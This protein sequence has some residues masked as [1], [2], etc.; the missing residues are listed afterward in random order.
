MTLA[1]LHKRLDDL[2]GRVDEAIRIEREAALR[3]MDAL[4]IL[5]QHTV[6]YRAALAMFAVAG[7]NVREV[8]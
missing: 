5:K 2:E 1:D 8:A 3:R 6:N 7:T 4:R